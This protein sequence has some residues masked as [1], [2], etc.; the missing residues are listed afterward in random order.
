VQ[1]R[2]ETRCWHALSAKPRHEKAVAHNLEIQKLE[3][4]LPLSFTWR[5]WS[6][7]MKEV[8]MPL[9]PGYVFCHFGY[10]E[11]L[12][13]L[14][15]PGVVSIVGF[16]RQGPR[17]DQDGGAGRDRRHARAGEDAGACRSEC[18][19]AATIRLSRVGPRCVE[20]G[21]HP[22]RGAGRR[23]VCGSIARPSMTALK[24]RAPAVAFCPA[25]LNSRVRNCLRYSD[26]A[27]PRTQ[28]RVVSQS[29]CLLAA[30][31]ER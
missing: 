19:T 22:E 8:G 14:N 28:L 20:F 31:E 27:R 5:I 21:L 4:L 18:G 25:S 12:R 13:I 24:A 17:T 26:V 29:A 30:E 3:S 16:A 1:N 7:R 6:D 2:I 11:C 23:G 15:T 10:R 9:F